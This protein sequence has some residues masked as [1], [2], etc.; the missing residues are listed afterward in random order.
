MV[1]GEN[2]MKK[3][4]NL[5]FTLSSRLQILTIHSSN[6]SGA[7]ELLTTLNNSWLCQ[8]KSWNFEYSI[9]YSS[10]KRCRRYKIYET[11]STSRANFTLLPFYVQ[12]REMLQPIP[13]YVEEC[14]IW[15]SRETF[16]W[17]NNL[18][19]S[20]GRLAVDERPWH[21]LPWN[22]ESRKPNKGSFFEV[23][24]PLSPS[25][26]SLSFPFF[27]PF[28]DYLYPLPFASLN[29][30]KLQT[31]CP[32]S[33]RSLSLLTS[34]SLLLC[35]TQVFRQLQHQTYYC[36]S[37]PLITQLKPQDVISSPLFPDRC[38]DLRGFFHSCCRQKMVSA[39]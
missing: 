7:R 22:G 38:I 23:L 18:K 12:Q 21:V 39:W 17:F 16:G 11:A 34:R 28:F 13:T 29:F 26:I 27:S 3:L 19:F 33:F 5:T 15:N 31:N 9:E 6:F 35:Q 32:H 24:L 25:N 8:T 2:E 10:G 4:F 36:N 20:N 30:K 1:K 14:K 37:L